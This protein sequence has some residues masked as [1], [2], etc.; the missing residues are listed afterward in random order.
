MADFL[1]HCQSRLQGSP[2]AGSRGDSSHRPLHVV[3][4]VLDAP[5]AK[6]RGNST[7]G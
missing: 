5:D 6:L 1:Q 4:Q 7:S 2:E 3:L